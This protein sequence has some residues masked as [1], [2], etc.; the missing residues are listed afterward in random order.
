MSNSKE[1]NKLAAWKGGV[2]K[3]NDSFNLFDRLV[4]DF[5]DSWWHDPLLVSRR[6]YRVSN[7]IE[8]DN[9]YTISVELPGYKRAEIE[10]QTINNV[11]QLTASN[12]KGKYIK[13]WSLSGVNLDNVTSKL[14]D[15]ILNISVPKT[16][17]SKP[18]TIE[19]QEVK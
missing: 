2:G 19:I 12:S 4:D 3:Y 18:K 7:I 14:E 11:I 8:N 9:D 15:G 13:S 16:P 17:E 5:Y 6:N 1:N 10:L